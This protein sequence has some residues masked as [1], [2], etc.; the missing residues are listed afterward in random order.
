[1]SWR[2]SSSRGGPVLLVL[3]QA[4]HQ[5][6]ARIALLL[7]GVGV[8]GHLGPRQEEL[9][10]HQH[11]LGRHLEEV[12]GDVDVH[13][14]HGLQRGQVGLGDP[15]DGDVEDVDLVLL[16]QVEQQVERPLEGRLARARRRQGEPER[17]GRRPVARGGARDGRIDVHLEF[18]SRCIAVRTCSMVAGRLGAGPGGP[19]AHHVPHVV[20][21]GEQLL[22]RLA[23]P[24]LVGDE[25]LEQLLLAVHAADPGGAA[26]LVHPAD[27]LGGAVDAVQVEDAAH[28]RVPGVLA[29]LAG[30]VG[31]RPHDLLGGGLGPLTQLDGVPVAL[32]HLAPVDADHLGGL[33][34]ERLGLGEDLAVVEVELAGDL[35]GQLE[36]GDLV[37]A[38]RDHGGLVED[39]V[40][41]HEDRVA[42]EAVERQVAVGDLLAHLLVGR[43]AL[44]PA[45]G[46]DHAEEQEEL[47][48]LLHLALDEE[49]RPGRDRSRRPGSRRTSRTRPASACRSRGS[50]WSARAS[51]R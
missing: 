27:G 21:L 45:D 3:E 36:V 42:Q 37:G 43:G 8:L 48:V 33:G 1:M 16:H 40:G 34:E 11:E 46:G 7:G 15:G 29:Q 5:L 30:R 4:A 44:Q 50:S 26:V 47:G 18:W 23:E 12:A 39:D 9:R 2:P 32:R 24:L 41:G 10:L 13:L 17:L 28:L 38:H 20:G 31:H 51:R 14:L 35:P 22:A 49:D 6:G 25:P 19:V